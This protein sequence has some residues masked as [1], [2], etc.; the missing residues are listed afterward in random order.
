MV[1]GGPK[2]YTGKALRAAH[3]PL[4]T[5]GLDVTGEVMEIA[6]STREDVLNH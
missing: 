3:A 1:F 6:G 2:A 4:V 5:K